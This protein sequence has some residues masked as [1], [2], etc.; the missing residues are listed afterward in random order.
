MPAPSWGG[1]NGWLTCVVLD[2]LDVRAEI[3][4]ALDGADIE[5]RPLWK[6]MHLQPAFTG[7]SA[8]VNGTSQGLF[9]HGLCLPSGSALSDDDVDRVCDVVERVLMIR[10]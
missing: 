6:P 1:W 4:A 8:Y 3:A 2:D 10:P 9:E 7:L 5:C